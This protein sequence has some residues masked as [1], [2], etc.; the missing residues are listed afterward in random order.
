MAGRGDYGMRGWGRLVTA[1][2]GPGTL[3]VKPDQAVTAGVLVAP[4]NV[5]SIWKGP[6]WGVDDSDSGADIEAHYAA[7]DFTTA[8]YCIAVKVGGKWYISCFIPAGS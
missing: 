8:D 3:F 4:D 5:F 7:Q 2:P 6:G 1:A